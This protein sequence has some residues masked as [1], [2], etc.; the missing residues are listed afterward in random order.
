[1]LA[2]EGSPTSAEPLSPKPQVL[3]SKVIYQVIALGLNIYEGIYILQ[4][5]CYLEIL[6]NTTNLI[7]FLGVVTVVKSNTLE[8]GLRTPSGGINQ[9][10]LKIWANAAEKIYFGRT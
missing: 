2:L 7:T 6:Y 8:H 1:M 4:Y 5:V 3:Q 10:Y 9:R